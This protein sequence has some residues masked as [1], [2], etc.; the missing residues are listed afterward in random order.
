MAT[1]VA[2]ASDSAGKA[3]ESQS[4]GRWFYA[5]WHSWYFHKSRFTLSVAS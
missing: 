3:V 2:T 4:A 1:A 5:A